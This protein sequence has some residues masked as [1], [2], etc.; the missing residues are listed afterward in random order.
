MTIDLTT[1]SFIK[2]CRIKARLTDTGGVFS[3]EEI[4][5][6]LNDQLQN[7]IVPFYMTARS[8]YFLSHQDIP[9]TNPLSIPSNAINQKIA[10][11]EIMNHQSSC[12]VKHLSSTSSNEA[13]FYFEGDKIIFRH[14][15]ESSQLR[16]WFYKRPSSLTHSYTSVQSVVSA[17]QIL[18]E[19]IPPNWQKGAYEFNRSLPTFSG[20]I[21][22]A[23]I[24]N[25]SGKHATLKNLS[26]PIQPGDLISPL[27]TSAVANIPYEASYLLVLLTC[28]AFNLDEQMT[29]NLSKEIPM[30]EYR[31]Q[32]ISTPR[33][34]DSY[35]VFSR[36][37]IFNHNFWQ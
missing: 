1:P 11:I 10:R 26:S 30:V 17:N 2:R 18:L 34:D 23:T 36:K 24:I 20:N 5:M 19:S 13:G 33:T 7:R 8:N 21:A 16:I 4:L 22:D 25:F 9:F 14:I 27:G 32:Q 29:L 12:A 31:L 28:L 35:Q 15:D 6:H 37:T 3:D